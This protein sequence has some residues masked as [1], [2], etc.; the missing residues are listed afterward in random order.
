MFVHV[1][2]IY[3]PISRSS[4]QIR[5][6]KVQRYCREQPRDMSTL[7]CST[8]RRLISLSE[9]YRDCMPVH[10]KHDVLYLILT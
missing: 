6:S 1:I 2:V 7:C 10:F 3:T 5:Y 8:E 4:D 9:L